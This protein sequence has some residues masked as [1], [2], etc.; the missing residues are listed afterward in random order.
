MSAPGE[1][2]K[3]QGATLRES[4]KRKAASV[5]ARE[6]YERHMEMVRTEQARL[7][8]EAAARRAARA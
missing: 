8:L 1:A 4:G 7:K 5:P 6:H 3:K 2:Y